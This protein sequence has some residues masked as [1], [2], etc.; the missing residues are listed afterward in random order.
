[1]SRSCTPRRGTT[2]PIPVRDAGGSPS[3]L[4][5]TG[6]GVTTAWRT[7]RVSSASAS[8]SRTFFPC[9]RVSG[10][11]RVSRCIRITILTPRHGVALGCAYACATSSAIEHLRCIIDHE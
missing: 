11:P 5:V 7:R 2:D 9:G 6:T 10:V 4:T 3:A 8:W 1:M